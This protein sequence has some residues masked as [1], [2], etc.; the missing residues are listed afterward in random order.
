VRYCLNLAIV[1]AFTAIKI[2]LTPF[3]FLFVCSLLFRSM[4]RDLMK[5][6][7]YSRII[8]VMT[9]LCPGITADNQVNSKA[10]PLHAIVALGGEEI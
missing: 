5:S 8:V 1:F 10:V 9:V 4:L 7:L 2:L 6:V 3:Y